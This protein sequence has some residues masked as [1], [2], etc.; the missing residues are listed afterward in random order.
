MKYLSLPLLMLAMFLGTWA[1]CDLTISH[2]YASAQVYA[3]LAIGCGILRLAPN[4][5]K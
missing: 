3:L 2:N 4:P 1:L 5:E